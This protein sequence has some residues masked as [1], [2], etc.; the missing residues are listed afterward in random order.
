MKGF[1][2]L[3]NCESPE[4]EV[5][6]SGCT[7]S[8]AHLYDVKKNVCGEGGY[9]IRDQKFIVN[10]CMSRKGVLFESLQAL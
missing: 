7:K 10:V 3:Q 2:L 1:E 8:M 4:F 9:L 5:I 6:I